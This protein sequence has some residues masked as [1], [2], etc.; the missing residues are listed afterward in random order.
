MSRFVSPEDAID[1]IAVL[2]FQVNE[3]VEDIGARRL[4]TIME[5]LFDDLSFSAPGMEE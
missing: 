5:R 4:H 2:A 1:E 3:S